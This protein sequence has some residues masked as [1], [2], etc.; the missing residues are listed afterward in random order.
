MVVRVFGPFRLFWVFVVPG[1]SE[2]SKAEL[3]QN[4]ILMLDF[5]FFGEAFNSICWGAHVYQVSTPIVLLYSTYVY[6]QQTAQSSQSLC[7][8]KSA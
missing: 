1:F 2:L 4:K 7:S 6:A 3:A 5:F 8:L